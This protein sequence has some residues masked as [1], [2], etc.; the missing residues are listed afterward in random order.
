MPTP[1]NIVPLRPV[2]KKTGPTKMKFK[3]TALRKI[4]EET[5]EDCYLYDLY[6][7]GLTLRKQ[8]DRWAFYFVKRC[9]RNFT[10]SS[11][12]TGIRRP[13]SKTFKP[14]LRSF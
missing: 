10:G 12:L 5:T 11:L 13:T 7:P 14:G 8:G 1:D 9:G 4:V 3:I 2:A 6:Q